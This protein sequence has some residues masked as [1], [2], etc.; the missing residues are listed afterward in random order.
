MLEPKIN[1]LVYFVSNVCKY[2]N[3]TANYH[4]F[5]YKNYKC[6]DINEFLIE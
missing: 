4:I 6:K 2:N 3:K 1:L 5:I